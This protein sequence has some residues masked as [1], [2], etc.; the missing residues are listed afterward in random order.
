MLRNFK[1]APLA[2]AVCFLSIG[3]TAF[4]NDANVEER[5]AELENRVLQAE[6]RAQAAEAR[7]KQME[8]SQTDSYEARIT[9]L[10][11]K[12]DSEDGFSFS[13]YARSGLLLGN[14]GKSLPG[15]PYATPAGSVG[16]AVGRLGNEPDTYVHA[17]LNHRQ[18]YDNGTQQRFQVSFA[19]SVE[20][21]NDWTSNES[22][23]NV[24]QVFVELSHLPSLEGGAFED[25]TLWAGK[26]LDRDIFDIHWLDS[27]V[28]KLAGL[29]AGVYDVRLGDDWTSNFSLYGRSFDDFAVNPENTELT[30]DTDSLILTANNYVGNWQLMVNA[31]SA[32][33]N[34]QRL[35]KGP[36]TSAERGFHGMLGYQGDSF[37][38]LAD[39]SYRAALLHGQGLGAEVKQVGANGELLDDAQSTRLAI[40]GTT[41][42][43]PSWRIAPMLLAETS[44][45]R[46]VQGDEYQWASFNA[47]IANELSKNFEMQYEASYQFMDLDPQGYMGRN[48]VE[49]NF[50]KFTIAPTFKPSVG[51]FWKRPEIRAFASYTS[52]DDELNN[53][54]GNDAFGQE[55][56]TGGQ[57]S[58]GVQAE[59]W[60]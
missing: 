31:I 13:A 57:W 1:L 3:S 59:T 52:W 45:D 8:S 49:G 30:S 28:V 19:D 5:L 7:A 50:T 23:L 42:L 16:G 6:R 33:D 29:G 9:D 25:S 22:E 20:T 18:T 44:K 48:A 34:D 40:Y 35:T 15:G 36:G 47:R 39:G 14:E 10:E 58:F 21:S 46:F 41:Y 38:G 56:Y 54:A 51:G 12:A 2:T 53:F 17:R 37:F 26:R 4:A 27:D 32:T 55:G 24:R 11:E 60:F 43:T